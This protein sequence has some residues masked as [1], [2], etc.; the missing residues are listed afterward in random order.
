MKSN[1]C[2]IGK[3]VEVKSASNKSFVGLKGKIV[4]ETK[5]SFTLEVGNSK[6]IVLKSKTVFY[7][8]NVTITGDSIINRCEQRIKN[9]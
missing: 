6:K 9:K 5:F 3:T 1:D 7:I 4:N 2:F 8:D